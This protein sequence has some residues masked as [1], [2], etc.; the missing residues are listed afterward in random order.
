MNEV[1]KRI[2]RALKL[3]QEQGVIR[4]EVDMWDAIDIKKQNIYNIRIGKQHFTVKHVRNLC[5]KFNIDAN[6]AMA[7][8]PISHK[9]FKSTV[10]K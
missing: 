5:R 8:V 1:D 6:W 2:F 9:P 7:L 10:I 4:F 3:L